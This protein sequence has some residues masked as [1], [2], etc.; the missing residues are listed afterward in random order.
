MEVLQR[1]VIQSASSLKGI[2][3]CSASERA[4]EGLNSIRNVMIARSVGRVD[5]VSSSSTSVSRE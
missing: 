4:D 5:Y 2:V 3:L 1:P